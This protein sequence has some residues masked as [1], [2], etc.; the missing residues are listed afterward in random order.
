MRQLHQPDWLGAV[1][2][3]G[4]P[5]FIT[6]FTLDTLARAV[7]ITVIPLQALELLGDAQR[8][9]VLYFAVSTAGLMGSLCVPWLVSRLRRRW[10]LSLG[11]LGFVAAA[12]LLAQHSLAALVPGMVVFLFGA[13]CVSIC[14]N[15]YVLDHIPRTAYARFEPTRMLFSGC[16]WIV[17]PALGVYLG[18]HLAMWAPYAASAG[19]A[20]IQIG[21]FWFLRL[22]EHPVV[23]RAAAPPPDPVRFVRR[24]FAQPRLGLAWLLAVGRAGWWSMFFIYTP[25]YAVTM[26]LGE[27]AGGL[28][29]SAGSAALFVVTFW[30]WLG[31][32]YGIR[33]LLVGG[34]AATGAL[35]IAVGVAAVSPWLGAGVLLVAAVGASSIDGAGNV[36]FMSAVRTGE[37]SEMTTV[38]ATYRDVARL[39]TP[40]LYAL[41]RQVFA[42]PAVFATSGL[43]MLTLSGFS[44]YIPRRLGRETRHTL[45]T[46]TGR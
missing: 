8:V 32:R 35:T 31:R 42:L 33:N 43:I 1:A 26:G 38:Y 39:S 21:Y 9:S 46:A 11:A 13:A 15:L 24:F 19:F 4:A 12:P 27:E 34:Y 17:G 45:R 29:S 18:N 2:R 41:I 20:L 10:T 28:I 36:P 30:G 40:G 37:R 6:L 3:A 44:R 14:L 23:A 25:I 22:T 5:A 7:L 16:G